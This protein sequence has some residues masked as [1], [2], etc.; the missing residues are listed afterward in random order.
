VTEIDVLVLGG[1][2][3]DTIVYV[4]EL[5]LP[6]ADGYLVPRIV[7]RAGHTGD[8]VAVGLSALGLRTA[9]VDL[10]GDDVEGD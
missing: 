7:R 4:P 3:V 2:G 10:L 5:P 9:L 1:A 6:F 8:G